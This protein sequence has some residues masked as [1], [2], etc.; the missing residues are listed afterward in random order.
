MAHVVTNADVV[1]LIVAIVCATISLVIGNLF[2]VGASGV[3][4]V[5]TLT[6]WR[7]T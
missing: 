4:A 5:C 6:P 3:L 2:L 1:V 7:R